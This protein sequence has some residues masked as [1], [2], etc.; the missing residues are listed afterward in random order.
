MSLEPKERGL[1]TKRLSVEKGKGWR[2]FILR[3]PHMGH[4]VCG[5][6][7]NYHLNLRMNE[8]ELHKERPGTLGM[9]PN[10]CSRNI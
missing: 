4:A 3:A 9:T 2:P 10:T 7:I 5:C 6:S 8:C 1:K